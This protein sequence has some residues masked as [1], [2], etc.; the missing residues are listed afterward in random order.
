LLWG[1]FGYI[2]FE[3]VSR[4]AQRGVPGHPNA[5]Q[6]ELYVVL[7]AAMML[8]GIGLVVFSNRTPI[9]LYVGIVIVELV[10]VIPFLLVYGGGV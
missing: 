1:I 10:A 3:L 9:A 6:W 2:G 7:P 8:I 4:V 5:R